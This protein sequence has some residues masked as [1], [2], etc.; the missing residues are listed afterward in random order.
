MH[1]HPSDAPIPTVPDGDPGLAALHRRYRL[2][3]WRDRGLRRGLAPKLLRLPVGVSVAPR[4]VE[5]LRE[6]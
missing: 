3:R 6:T 5:R 4:A 2:E 1:A